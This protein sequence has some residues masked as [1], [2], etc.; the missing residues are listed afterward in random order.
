MNVLEYTWASWEDK[1]VRPHSWNVNPLHRLWWTQADLNPNHH[2]FLPFLPPP[3]YQTNCTISPAVFP[4]IAAWHCWDGLRN[5]QEEGAIHCFLMPKR[6]WWDTV[7][8]IGLFLFHCRVP[9]LEW[10]FHAKKKPRKSSK[11]VFEAPKASDIDYGTSQTWCRKLVFHIRIPHT[12]DMRTSEN[13]FSKGRA[14]QIGK[15]NFSFSPTIL[16]LGR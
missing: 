12:I 5:Q 3:Y 8:I 10:K 7:T 14:V 11:G 15:G 13:C 9:W 2:C 1:D 16:A 6:M 4:S